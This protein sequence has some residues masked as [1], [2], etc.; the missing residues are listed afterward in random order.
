VL[1]HEAMKSE[2]DVG[3]YGFIISQTVPKSNEFTYPKRVGRVIK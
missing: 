3:F 2:P 1:V